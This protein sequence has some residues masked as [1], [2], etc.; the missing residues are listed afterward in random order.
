MSS[1][2][3]FLCILLLSN[4]LSAIL[5]S[6][7]PLS[8]LSLSIRVFAPPLLNPPRPP[9][10]RGGQ[11]AQQGQQG[12]HAQSRRGPTL[13]GCVLARSRASL[14]QRMRLHFPLRPACSHSI[15]SHFPLISNHLLS[16]SPFAIR[17]FSVPLPMR[18]SCAPRQIDGADDEPSEDS[19][20]GGGVNMQDA[21]CACV[22]RRGGLMWG[23]M[24]PANAVWCAAPRA[25]QTSAREHAT[26]APDLS[27]RRGF[28]ADSSA[29][30][31]GE[32][33]Q[34]GP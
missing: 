23:V 26:A 1:E 7:C 4:L 3:V 5:H 30:G 33:V 13:A 2:C 14:M 31:L 17:L 25:G 22:R 28:A 34:H 29:D 15:F 21:P 20:P 12:Q 9:G 16:T 27:S 19:A 10:R 24:T 11:Q 32:T 18:S 6:V 8:F